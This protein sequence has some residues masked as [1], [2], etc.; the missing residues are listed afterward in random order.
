MYVRR[1]NDDNILKMQ[2]KPPGGHSA[3]PPLRAS[4]QK[5][6]SCAHSLLKHIDSMIILFFVWCGHVVISMFVHTCP[7]PKHVS[8]TLYLFR[9]GSNLS[10][11]ATEPFLSNHLL[12]QHGGESFHCDLLRSFCMK[13]KLYFIFNQR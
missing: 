5:S 2:E 12:K 7:P 13:R 6:P 1:E 9:F 11:G 3:L 4:G 10:R 8:P